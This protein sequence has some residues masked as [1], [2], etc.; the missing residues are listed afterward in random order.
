MSTIKKI[1]IANRGEI[2]C[3]ILR[4]L[5]RMAIPGAVVYHAVDKFSPAVGM[6]AEAVEIDGP[7]PVAAYLDVEQMVDACRQT[8]A[9]AVTPALAFWRKTPGSRNGCWR[10]GSP[11]SALC[12]KPSN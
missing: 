6:A 10:K 5:D 11:L 1:L 3:R 2:A 7:T 8:G 12:R 4:T 9:D